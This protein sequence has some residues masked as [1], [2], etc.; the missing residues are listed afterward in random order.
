MPD[1][2][3]SNPPPKARQTAAETPKAN[4]DRWV[5]TELRKLYDDI[6]NEPLPADL[7]A[8]LNN[9]DLD[10]PSKGGKS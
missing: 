3:K 9:I 8:L 7:L 10:N 4:A 2:S 6:A 1:K 5:D